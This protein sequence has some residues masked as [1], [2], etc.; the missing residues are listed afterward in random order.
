M[1]QPEKEPPVHGP[2]DDAEILSRLLDAAP[3]PM[4]VH[5]WSGRPRYCNLAASRALGCTPEEFCALPAWGWV[6]PEGRQQTDARLRELRLHGFSMF[7]SCAFTENGAARPSEVTVSV[8]DVG[9]EQLLI[10]AIR[11]AS[12]ETD[13]DRRVKYLAF[14]DRLTGISN[15]TMFEECMATAIK[16]AEERGTLCGVMYLDLDDFKPV[17]DTFG[18][19]FGD[20]VLTVVA[21]RISRCVRDE[22]DLVA[23]LGG[24]EFAVLLTE[25]SAP[26]QLAVAGRNV[27]VAI[28]QPVQVG[29][30]QVN[31]SASVGL[32]VY[33]QGEAPDELLVRADHAMYRA[34]RDG[35]SGAE[36][37]LRELAE[38][39]EQS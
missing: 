28:A 17:N 29:S 21:R 7:A 20:A 24:D 3:D 11:L 5:E 31:V 22:A 15:R 1:P 36:E 35:L 6:A 8:A 2:I 25:L 26:E 32:A 4:I 13:D 37:F 30:H 12:P 14:H 18:H 23:R 33:R 39:S 9:S 10:A 19:A 38:E 16:D 27:P 34:K